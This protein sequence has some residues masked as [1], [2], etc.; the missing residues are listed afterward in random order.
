MVYLTVAYRF[1]SGFSLGLRI[2][3]RVGECVV[4]FLFLGFSCGSYF[5]VVCVN[6]LGFA[7][8]VLVRG[9]ASVFD[10]CFD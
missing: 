5:Y 3:W 4:G 7:L 10:A 8:D 9:L 1:A 2:G 6:L